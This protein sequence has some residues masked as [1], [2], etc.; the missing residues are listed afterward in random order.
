MRSREPGARAVLVLGS[1]CTV[2]I[3]TIA[4]LRGV[5]GEVALVYFDPPT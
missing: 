5:I 3:G 2:G 4:G 1:D